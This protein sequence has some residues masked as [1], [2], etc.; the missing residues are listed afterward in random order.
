MSKCLKYNKESFGEKFCLECEKLNYYLC[1]LCG[2]VINKSI[3]N[4]KI[5]GLVCEGC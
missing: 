1:E 3:Y 2:K 5:G 4:K